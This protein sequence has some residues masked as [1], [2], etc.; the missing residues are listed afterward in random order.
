MFGMSLEPFALG[1]SQPL[2]I[3]LQTVL[4]IVIGAHP[5]G[6][7]EHRPLGYRLGEVIA[8]RAMALGEDA[9]RLTPLVCS[10][11][12]YLNDRA[13]MERPTIAIGDPA[14]NAATAF[15]ANRLPAALVIEGALRIHLD[16]EF[17]DLNTCMW[18]VDRQATAMAVEAFIERY[19]VEFVG[20]VAG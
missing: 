16:P 1:G 7:I 11:L 3:D 6:E 12:W 18:G 15:L 5:I 8:A 10:D 13:L 2:E 4:P 14:I 17:I 9:H 20:E 19:L